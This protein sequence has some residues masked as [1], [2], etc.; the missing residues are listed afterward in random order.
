MQADPADSQPQD[1]VETESPITR[2]TNRLQGEADQ[3]ALDHSQSGEFTDG[4]DH[5]AMVALLLGEYC[6][7]TGMTA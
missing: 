2:G 1:R 4:S 7:R 6:T 5:D 3:T